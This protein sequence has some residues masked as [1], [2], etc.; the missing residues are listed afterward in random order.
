MCWRGPK[1]PPLW[2]CS[3]SLMRP[4]DF[5]EQPTRCGPL[6]WHIAGMQPDSSDASWHQVR[7]HIWAWGEK[8]VLHPREHHT[9]M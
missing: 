5:P 8:V 6:V 1:T 4:V 9:I 2:R 7:I 3:H